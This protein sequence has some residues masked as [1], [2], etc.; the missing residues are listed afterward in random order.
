MKTT[1][2]FIWATAFGIL[3]M[4]SCTDRQARKPSQ[5]VPP[6]QAPM[7]LNQANV[8]SNAAEVNSGEVMLNPEHGMPGH[9]CEIPV[10]APLNG[11]SSDVGT[12][13]NS[14]AATAGPRAETQPMAPKVRLNPPHGEPGH[15][16]N[17]PVGEPLP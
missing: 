14:G 8:P 15:D 3:G 16:C 17:V 6:I 2:T 12:G 10:G 7:P 11:A 1:H 9:R 13:I 5:P 4:L